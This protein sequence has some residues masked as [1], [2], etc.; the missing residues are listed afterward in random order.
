MS[1]L[2]AADGKSH[3]W[4]SQFE[5]NPTKQNNPKQEDS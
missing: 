2:S 3:T 4:K 1:I 5:R